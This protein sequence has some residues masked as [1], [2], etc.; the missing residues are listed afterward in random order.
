MNQLSD[1]STYR[2]GILQARA[3]RNLRGFMVRTLKD[4]DLT[5]TEWSLLGVVSD[6]TK[7]GGIRVSDLAHLL[8]VETSFVTNM[9]KKLIN[10]GYFEYGYDEDDG[11][12]KLVLGT[13]K[14]HL[15][16]V[17]I[18]KHMRKE[19]REWLS[20]VKP[21]ELVHYINVLNKISHLTDK[22]S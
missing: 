2:T 18:E 1:F 6:E 8:D 5:S 12:V 11:R 3:Y 21:K 22:D 13:N 14:C 10:K 16:V 7:N 4:H 20:E 15:K 19:M 17:E 9:V